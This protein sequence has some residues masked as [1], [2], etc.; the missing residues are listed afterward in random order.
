MLK[1]GSMFL[2]MLLMGCSSYKI[3]FLCP[4]YPKP[5][6]EVL[7]AILATKN[8]A[9]TKWLIDQRKLKEKLDICNEK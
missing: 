6:Q 5:S 9:T 2:C 1:I 8:E 3:K 4:Q 7:D